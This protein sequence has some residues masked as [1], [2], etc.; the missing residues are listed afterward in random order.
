MPEGKV[1]IP[2]TAD[3]MLAEIVSGYISDIESLANNNDR[4]TLEVWLAPI[5]AAHTRST[6]GLEEMESQR[7]YNLMKQLYLELTDQVEAEEGE[8]EG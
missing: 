1:T 2:A 8:D 4:I 3:D 5:L 6:L 7:S